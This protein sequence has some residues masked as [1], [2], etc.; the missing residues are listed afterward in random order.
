MPSN[1]EGEYRSSMAGSASMSKP[2]RS[3]YENE[4]HFVSPTGHLRSKRT[5]QFVPL[6]SPLYSK[7]KPDKISGSKFGK[8]HNLLAVMPEEMAQKN[9]SDGD[10]EGRNEHLLKSGSLALCSNPDCINCSAAYIVKRDRLQGSIHLD[11]KLHEI[12]YG[13]AGGSRKFTSCFN[14]YFPIMN[15]HTRVVQQWNRFIF[16]CCLGMVVFDPV[17]FLLPSIQ[18][19]NKCIIMDW[20]LATS[21][22]I[23]R[24]VID[25]I[26]F[27]HMLLQFRV[28][29]VAPE[30]RVVGAGDLVDQPKKIALHYL[31]HNFILD[32]CVALPLPQIMLLFVIPEAVGPTEAVYARDVLCLTVII[33]YIPRMIK[34]FQLLAGWSTGGFVFES[35]WTSFVM[36]M[37]M[38]LL[39]GHVVGTIWYMFGLQR[40]N[41]CLHAACSDSYILRCES[42]I[43]CGHGNNNSISAWQ[44]WLNDSASGGCL[45]TDG[46]YAYGIYNQAVLLTTQPSI[47]TRLIYAMCWGFLQMA[48]LVGNQIPSYNVWENLF[49]TFLIGLG[50]LLFAWLL[51]NMQ[52][53]L[54]ALGRRRFEM[55]I[56]QRDFEQWLSRRHLPEELQRQVR[57]AERFSWAATRGINEEQLLENLPED[58]QRDI[59]RHFFKFLRKVWIFTLMDEP[60]LDAIYKRLRQKF[61]IQGSDILYQGGPVEKM[62]VI[63]RGKVESIGV[64]GNIAPLSEG[65]VC[66]EE[67]LTWYLE[68][69]SVYKDGGKIRFPG[70]HLFSTRTVK[71]LTNVET[72]AL[73]TADLEEVATMFPRLL[74]HPHVQRAIRYESPYWRNKAA[75]Q[76]QVVWR[77]RQRR[78]KKK[79]SSMSDSSHSSP[80]ATQKQEADSAKQLYMYG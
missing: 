32:L 74:R 9:W 22:A 72:F 54:S 10:H 37:F 45:T 30:S 75:I 41:D 70:Q 20:S 26:Y 29:Y 2:P 36:N 46:G 80:G 23:V 56:R 31:Q 38:Y 48:T 8:Q 69:S 73:R 61:Y 16:I 7:Q 15:P 18:M 25:F 51:G 78:L 77:Y 55:Q 11:S 65:D 27:I 47:I 58:I 1:I 21:F 76:I 49:A 53:F 59:R 39:S 14:S 79:A 33:Q 12:L 19:H 66:G 68:H 4:D 40:V 63:V 24:S 3:S 35:A 57:Q 34:F 6:S 13:D 17:F 50:L 64:D 42:F 44:Q 5:T 28:A 43:E 60:I 52:N 71:C 62:V 67:L